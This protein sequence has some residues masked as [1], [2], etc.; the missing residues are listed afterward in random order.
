[1]REVVIASAVRTPIGA[2][3]GKFK[4]VSAVQLGTI[5]A[6]EA[7][8]RAKVDP[9]MV[10]EVIFGNVLQ[11]G[12]GQNVARQVS[13]YAGIPVE[14]PSFTVNKVC[15]SG[16]KTVALAAQAILAG[17]ADIVLAGGTENMSQAPYLLKSARWGQRMGNGQIEDYMVQDGLWDIFNNYHMGI[18]A[19]NI[20][21]KYGFTREEQDKLAL[22]S[23]NRAEAAIKNER[24][25]E[26]I[27]AVEIPQRKGDPIIADTDEYPKFGTTAEV[28]AK[29][30]PAFKKDGTVTAGNASGINDGA[31][32][33]VVMSKEKADELGITPLATIASYA[34]AGVDPSIMGTGPIPATRKA[35]AKVNMTIEELDLIEANEA[36]AAQALSVIKELNLD[37]EKTNVNGGAI[38]LGHPIGASG[39]RILVSL[40]HEMAKR[41]AKNGLATLCIGGG[42]GIAMIVKR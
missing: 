38:A 13:I 35:L 23:Q 6:K 2:F 4:D 18:T 32:A 7:L 34:S 37:I 22:D 3:G 9:N 24:F 12:L 30:R 10:D 28:L 33:L 21:E 36:F 8:K 31:A 27:V 11:A 16:L 17:E 19:E 29:L 26:E 14:V 42:Q 1:M 25:K 41:D 40:L 15:G 39:A 5:V 20:A